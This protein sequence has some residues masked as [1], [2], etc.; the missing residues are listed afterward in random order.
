[1][2]TT[3]N[4]QAYE[5]KITPIKPTTR[6]TLAEEIVDL[7]IHLS[8]GISTMVHI[9]KYR[10]SVARPR[11]K[12]FPSQI[13]L[14][15]WCQDHGVSDAINGGFSLHHTETLLGEHRVEGIEVPHTPFTT[16]WDSTRGS[17]HVSATGKLKIGP[18]DSFPRRPR[19]D[20]LQA[21]PLLVRNGRSVIIHGQDPEGIASSSEQFD[22]DWTLERFPRAAIGV[23]NKYI[24]TVATDGYVRP[25]HE[26]NNAGLRLSELA[27][28]MVTLGANSA[29]NLD[30]GSSATQVS[31]GRLINR[32]SAGA[33]DNYATFPLGRPI[34]SA[35]I[36]EPVQA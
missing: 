1:M 25:E 26:A 27:D 7:R 15:S 22:D 6:H 16:P 18:R 36:F 10:K 11:L 31:D 33:R 24:W 19:G 13:G 4:P 8:E 2:A 5:T 9:V 21:G 12:I 29:L 23:S 35:I 3:T 32:P 20:L 14:L 34:P 28:I 17:V 30:G